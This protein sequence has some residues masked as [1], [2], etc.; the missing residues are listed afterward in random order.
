[1]PIQYLACEG[2]CLPLGISFSFVKQGW[3]DEIMDVKDLGQ[4]LAP[5]EQLSSAV[6]AVLMR[7]GLRMPRPKFCLPQRLCFS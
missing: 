7:L 2:G 6:V 1:M 3:L 5:S 4:G